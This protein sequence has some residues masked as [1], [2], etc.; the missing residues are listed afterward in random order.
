MQ[1]QSTASGNPS[2][3]R[4]C[5][6]LFPAA[7]TLWLSSE[8]TKEE[9]F[10]AY[11]TYLSILEYHRGIGGR[12]CRPHIKIIF[13]CKQVRMCR[14]PLPLSIGA[15]LSMMRAGH[16]PPGL[17]KNSAALIASFTRRSSNYC[18]P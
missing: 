7:R 18:S 5:Q 12:M 13:L 3:F 1:H 8:V 10:T 6:N 11:T 2:L 16:L 4:L 14:G 9:L 15:F 17:M